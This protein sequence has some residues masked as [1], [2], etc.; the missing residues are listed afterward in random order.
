M[1][2]NTF[3]ITKKMIV[4]IA[5]PTLT[6]IRKFSCYEWHWI[7]Y[8]TEIRLRCFLILNTLHRKG[9]VSK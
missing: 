8:E 4:K 5:V 3:V 2:N 1:K 6:L 7:R 9:S